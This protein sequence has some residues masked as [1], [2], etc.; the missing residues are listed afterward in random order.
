MAEDSQEEHEPEQDKPSFA[1]HCD[2]LQQS[3]DEHGRE[4]SSAGVPAAAGSSPAL[5]SLNLYQ[6]S[7]S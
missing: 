3:R 7:F 4:S 1:S 6:E 5:L 2:H